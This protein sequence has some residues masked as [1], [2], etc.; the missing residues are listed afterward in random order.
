MCI[1]AFFPQGGTAPKVLEMTGSLVPGEPIVQLNSSPRTIN[2]NRVNLAT[3]VSSLTLHQLQDSVM[4]GFS[5][6][7]VLTKGSLLEA[8]EAMPAYVQVVTIVYKVIQR[9]L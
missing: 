7:M 5:A 8:T 2:A 9:H 3:T 1:A 4:Q 6:I